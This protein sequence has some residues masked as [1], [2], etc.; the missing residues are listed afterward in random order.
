MIKTILC[1]ASKFPNVLPRPTLTLASINVPFCETD[2]EKTKLEKDYWKNKYTSL[3][4]R[5]YDFNSG[6]LEIDQEDVDEMVDKF[7]TSTRGVLMKLFMFSCK[8]SREQRAYEVASIMDTTALQLAIKYATKT[9]ALVLAQNLNML[10]E[11]KATVEYEKEKL[12][13]EQEQQKGN[14]F[15]YD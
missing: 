11:K 5:N 12:R 6:H 3:S 14:E 4:I 15:F 13:L 8:N 9:R 2:S 7:E 1:K 10:A